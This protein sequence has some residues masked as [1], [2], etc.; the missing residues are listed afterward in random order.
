MLCT[1][2]VRN[3]NILASFVEVNIPVFLVCV[4]IL[5]QKVQ[6]KNISLQCDLLLNSLKDIQEIF[7]FNTY[8]FCDI[9][10]N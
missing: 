10:I 1:K 7:I 2:A 5:A 6:Q 4:L 3:H 9:E 8:N